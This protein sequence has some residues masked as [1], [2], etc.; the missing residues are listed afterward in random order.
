MPR[1]VPVLHLHGRVGWFRRPGVG[2]RSVPVERYDANIG[3]PVAMLPDLDKSYDGD[4][5]IDSLWR[6]F[7]AALARAKRVF[8]LGHS[9]HDKALL[10]VL[11][12]SVESPKRVAVTVYDNS[13]E[14]TDA[15]AV[16]ARIR[17]EV[18]GAVTIPFRF[19]ANRE[20]TSEALQ[21]WL[22]ATQ[23]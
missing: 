12:D 6:E 17:E 23:V 13:G 8:V 19:E 15:A 2:L 21:G 9:L 10:R 1:Y 22:T 18:P 16:A 3:T 14:Q 11:R 7:G 5:T 4:P 20:L